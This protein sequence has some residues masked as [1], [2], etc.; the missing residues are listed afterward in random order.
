M[1]GA[2]YQYS[3]RPNTWS[4]FYP[5]AEEA[6]QYLKTVSRENDFYRF[7]NF[8]HEITRASWDN[9]QAKWTLTIND[10]KTGVA[11]EDRVDVFL[12]LSGPVK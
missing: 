5:A 10:I 7:M 9:D 11:F 6:R 2:I 3:W 4:E 8:R 1:P 12:D